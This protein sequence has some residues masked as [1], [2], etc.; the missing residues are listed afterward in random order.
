MLGGGI[1][2]LVASALGETW[3]EFN[4]TAE[5]LGSI[6]YLAVFGSAITFVSLTVLLRQLSAQAMAYLA[7]LLPFGALL[8]G[9]ALY[10]EEITGRALA[11]AALVTAG[12]LVAQWRTRTREPVAA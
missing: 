5:A 11:G 4:W 10:D 9:A 8:F 2:L 12:L 1:L 7:L 3:G 6:T